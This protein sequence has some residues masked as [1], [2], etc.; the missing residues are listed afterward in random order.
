MFA[1]PRWSVLS[2]SWWC[3]LRSLWPNL[4]THSQ[5]SR[6]TSL[7]MST[8]PRPP[9]RYASINSSFSFWRNPKNLHSYHPRHSGRYPRPPGRYTSM[10][11][12]I[13]LSEEHLHFFHFTIKNPLVGI[14]N[15]SGIQNHLDGIRNHLGNMPPWT[16]SFLSLTNVYNCSFLPPKISWKVSK[17]TWKVCLHESSHSPFRRCPTP[18]SYYH[19]RPPRRHLRPLERIEDIKKRIQDH[20]GGIQELVMGTAH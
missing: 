10:N 3:C 14:P 2:L 9:G 5:R 7:T 20:L 19:E 18:L 13:L 16:S 6:N 15:L 17:T 12:L 4:W 11:L 8:T 1:D